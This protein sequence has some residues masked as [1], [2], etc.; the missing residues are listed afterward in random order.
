[1]PDV[2]CAHFRWFYSRSAFD[3]FVWADPVRVLKSIAHRF[4]WQPPICATRS[5][6]N[7][8]PTRWCSIRATVRQPPMEALTMDPTLA[9]RSCHASLLAGTSAIR[10]ELD[11]ERAQLTRQVVVRVG[12]TVSRE[13]L[14]KSA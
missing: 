1:M 11:A 3:N 5:S 10:N 4:D 13:L 8:V 12:D 9:L 7:R 2:R 6:C 14:L